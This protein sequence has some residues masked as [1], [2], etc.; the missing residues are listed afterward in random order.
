VA[1]DH[2]AAGEIFERGFE[3]LQRFDVEVVGRFVE[4]QDVAALQQLGEVD[5]VAFTAGQLAD[6]LLLVAALEVEAPT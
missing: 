1:D 6:L 5:A 3:R 4:Q 2:G